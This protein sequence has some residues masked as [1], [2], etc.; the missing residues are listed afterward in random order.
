MWRFL[1]TE[2]IA[3]MWQYIVGQEIEFTAKASKHTF[4]MQIIKNNSINYINEFQ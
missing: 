1:F 3:N 4:S 2:Y